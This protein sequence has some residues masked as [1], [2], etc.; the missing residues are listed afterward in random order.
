MR[1]L[2]IAS[3]LTAQIFAAP[4][5]AA[6]IVDDSGIAATRSGSFAGARIRLAI[7]GGEPLRAGLVAAPM[8][9]A[10]RSDGRAV[11]RF[12][13]GVELGVTAAGSPRFAVAG[14][15]LGR[16]A[17]A[18]QSGDEEGSGPSPWLLVAGGVV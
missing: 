11:T 5:A 7:G 17:L 3:L 12:G 6:D 18:A 10:Q 8:I 2:L 15:E 13:E 9:R 14:R 16:R 1:S 4:A